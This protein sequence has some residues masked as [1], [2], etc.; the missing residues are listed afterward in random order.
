MMAAVA[1]S[2]AIVSALRSGLV[3]SQ[4]LEH[5]AAGLDA[6]VG[7]VGVDEILEVIAEA[8]AVELVAGLVPVGRAPARWPH[9]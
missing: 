5:L 3:P 8:Q 7:A 2:T 1:E 9:T 6:L 4:S